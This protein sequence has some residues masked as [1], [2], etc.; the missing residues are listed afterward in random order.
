MESTSTRRRL[1][2]AA[3]SVEKAAGA[4]R[5][6]APLSDAGRTVKWVWPSVPITSLKLISKPLH[7]GMLLEVLPLGWLGGLALISVSKPGILIRPCP[8]IS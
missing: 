8:V 7:E 3:A 5:Q 1:L 6:P 2:A 4:A